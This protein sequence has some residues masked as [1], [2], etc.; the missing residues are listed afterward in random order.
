MSSSSTSIRVNESSILP[1]T[2][3]FIV[4]RSITRRDD[5]SARLT[6]LAID[7]VIAVVINFTVA[8]DDFSLVDS[9][10]T[11]SNV[12]TLN[13]DDGSSFD[14]SATLDDG[15]SI[16]VP[17]NDDGLTPAYAGNEFA[18]IIAYL[19][20][21]KSSSYVIGAWPTSNYATSYNGSTIVNT[22]NAND[23]TN[24]DAPIDDDALGIN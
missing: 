4:T 21:G 22:I 19:N 1:T 13:A 16:N 6:I 15:D 2:C 20:D 11:H 7:A 9:K 3:C 8:N 18:A 17:S 5:S 24:A 14:A 23:A 12:I 10:S